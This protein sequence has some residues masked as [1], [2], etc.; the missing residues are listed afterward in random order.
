MPMQLLEAGTRRVLGTIS[1]EQFQT[2]VDG[3]EVAG[4][5]A[6]QEAALR[7]LGEARHTSVRRL[8]SGLS[9]QTVERGAE[10]L[11]DVDTW[12]DAQDW[13]RR[14]GRA[15]MATDRLDLEG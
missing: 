13:E 14:L 3:L 2:L 5:T 1:D 6:L 10:H 8:V 15:T 4:V 11:G 12:E 9:W 7:D